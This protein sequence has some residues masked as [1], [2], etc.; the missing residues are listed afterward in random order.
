VHT[1]IVVIVFWLRFLGTEK[2]ERWMRGG[3]GRGV[4]VT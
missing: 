4:V 3:G 2:L 1:L